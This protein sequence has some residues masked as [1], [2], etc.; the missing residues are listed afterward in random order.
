M[1]VV[2][3]RTRIAGLLTGGLV[4]ATAMLGA[5]G[6]GAAAT[7]TPPE[8]RAG[9]PSNAKV[10]SLWS[11]VLQPGATKSWHWNNAPTGRVYNVGLSPSGATTTKMC[12]F[13]VV[14]TWYE[15]THTGEREFYWRIKNVG[16]LACGATV[17]LTA[18]VATTSQDWGPF[19]PGV[20][21]GFSLPWTT[22]GT[23]ALLGLTAT[24]AQPSADC[25]A[26]FTE[27]HHFFNAS[28]KE[29][30]YFRALHEGTVKCGFSVLVGEVPV[31]AEVPL[32]PVT[33]G[34]VHKVVWNN[35]NPLTDTHVIGVDSASS[36]GTYCIY[37]IG[38]Q[39][40]RQ[41]LNGRV[42]ERELVFTVERVL[43][44]VWPGEG[45][46]ATAQLAVVK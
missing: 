14:K 17:V 40:Y 35:A 9:I 41:R 32:G 15:T 19:A 27:H 4:L 24:G 21:W 36:D 20:D 23:A 33:E 28:S 26:A 2:A 38:R 30:P 13:E 18:V 46:S 12:Q 42:P 16:S 37:D 11:G 5:S 45:C 43:E 3:A 22:P 39:Y 10:T 29:L 44:H 34:E 7:G 8:Q 25:R 31:V 6:A 1:R